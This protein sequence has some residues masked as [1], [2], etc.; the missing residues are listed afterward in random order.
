MYEAQRHYAEWKKSVSKGCR[1]HDLIYMTF[2][3]ER[4]YND[5]KQ[6]SGCQGWRM[7]GDYDHKVISTR[8]FWEHV[9]YSD[10]GSGWYQSIHMTKVQI[11]H[12]KIDFYMLI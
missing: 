2:S 9:S 11:A 4:N 12:W 8:E 7:G 6:I 1:L 3:K 5:D 10:D